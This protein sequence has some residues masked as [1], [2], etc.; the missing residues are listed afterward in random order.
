MSIPTKAGFLYVDVLKTSL[1]GASFR[2]RLL[3]LKHDEEEPP[4]PTGGQ[5]SFDQYAYMHACAYVCV[6]VC[7][8]VAGMIRDSFI[9]DSSHS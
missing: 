3:K 7:M 4:P 1:C 5:G 2:P 9:R 8:F 6:Y